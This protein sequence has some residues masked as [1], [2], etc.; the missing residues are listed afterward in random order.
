MT[1]RQIV[2]G[3]HPG[4]GRQLVGTVP[5]T[6]KNGTML[7]FENTKLTR[8]FSTKLEVNG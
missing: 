3:R 4:P 7:Q 6:K 1:D 8:D 5:E 2:R